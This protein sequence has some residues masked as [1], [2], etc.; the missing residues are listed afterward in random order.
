MI[1]SAWRLHPR[2]SM[3]AGGRRGEGADRRWFGGQWA[4]DVAKRCNAGLRAAV[5]PILRPAPT[6]TSLTV[7]VARLAREELR[8]SWLSPA[9]RRSPSSRFFPA[10]SDRTPARQGA[11]EHF[12]AYG[13]T[14]F[15]R[16]AGLSWLASAS[17]R[18]DWP[19]GRQRG[20]R[21][22]CK[23]SFQGARRACST[24]WRARAA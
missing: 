15:L 19:G 4:A 16:R 20:I 24:L 6:P 14:G 7:V 23:T 5:A 10:P 8:V 1:M 9:S 13:G 11:L 21:D 3:A 18:L 12:V 17:G 22:S 2:Q